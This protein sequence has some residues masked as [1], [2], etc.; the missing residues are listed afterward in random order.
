[1]RKSLVA[2]AVVALLSACGNGNPGAALTV[3]DVRVSA[4]EITDN[5][6]QVRSEIEALPADLITEVPSLTQ[7]AQMSV[8][9]IILH[10]ILTAA[11]LDKG[12]EVSQADI[13]TLLQSA[14]DQYG[15]ESIEAQLVSQ[16]AIPKSG[17][18][19]FARDVIIQNDLKELFVPGGS[20]EAKSAALVSY[21]GVLTESLNITVAPRYGKWDA[22]K[23]VTVPND[24]DLSAPFV[25]EQPA[26]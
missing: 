1:M 14:Y 7:L 12:I 2:V 5:V 15:Q 8:D 21:V 11:A 18:E 6:N 9:R 3:G 17:I 16:N 13:N 26:S 22:A 10:E 20:E 24:T 19:D 4:N 23:F 25:T